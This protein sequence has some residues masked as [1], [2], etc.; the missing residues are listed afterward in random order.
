MPTRRLWSLRGFYFFSFGG[1][2]ALFPFLPLLLQ[3]RGL[4]PARIAWVM[5]AIPLANMLVPPLWAAVADMLQAR[6]QLLR[7]A[8]LGT[9]LTTL[10][11]LPARGFAQH[12]AA[13]ALLSFFRAPLTTLGDAATYE[14][15]EGRHASYSTVRVFGSMGFATLVLTLGALQ[16]SQY[17][18]R[19]LWLT[20]AVYAAAGL[21]T[22]GLR[23]APV[24]RMRGVVAE[25][26]RILAHPAVVLYLLGSA[27]YYVA[28][29]I[30]DAFFGLYVRQLGHGDAVVGAAWALGVVV[31]VGIMFAAPRLF[32]ARP[33]EWVL[34]LC[35]L[36]S[37]VR[38]LLIAMLHGAV[39][40][41]LV[42]TL[43][44]V[45]FGLWYLSMVRAVQERAPSHLRASLQS[46]AMAAIGVGMMAGYAVGGQVFEAAGGKV[47]FQVAA[48]S[49]AL[50]LVLYVLSWRARGSTAKA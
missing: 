49:A 35:A 44:G 14:A 11:L 36:A 25:T 13:V 26:L 8:C 28:H 23:A 7:L 48:A 41:I 34:A 10:L 12:L 16:A 20:A 40:L 37:C 45:T 32:G 33:A 43:H 2:G 18:K 46:A 5:L 1:L 9:S 19:L 27:A 47:M 30:F 39:P 38:W 50:A 24:H 31:E 22:V 3:S 15:S 17:P 29:G 42:Q 6:L 4:D 21:S